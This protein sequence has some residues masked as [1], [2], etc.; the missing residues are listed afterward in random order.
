MENIRYNEKTVNMFY[1]PLLEGE[2]DLVMLLALHIK[3]N[4]DQF[5]S[6]VFKNHPMISSIIGLNQ[7]SQ[8]ITI[9]RFLMT[10]LL[11]FRSLFG[12]NIN[13]ILPFTAND[14]L[15][16]DWITVMKE[17][18]IPFLTEHKVLEVI[19]NYEIEQKKG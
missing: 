13:N 4:I 16:E 9:N 12:V 6:D 14:G 8:R 2:V 10:R 1:T 5:N 7:A 19:Y 3:E 15:T 11:M 17:F 18:M